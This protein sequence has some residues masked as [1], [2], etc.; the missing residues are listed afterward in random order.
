M[1]EEQERD[2]LENGGVRCPYCKSTH[3]SG[4]DLVFDTANLHQEVECSNCRKEWVDHYTL[5]AVEPLNN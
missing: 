3:I 4:S 1:T 5:V 2:Y